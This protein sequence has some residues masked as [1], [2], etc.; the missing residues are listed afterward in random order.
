[1]IL[2][3]MNN[4]YNVLMEEYAL[5]LHI[6]GNPAFSWWIRHVLVKRNHIIGNL[7]SKYWVRRHKFDVKISKSVQEAKSFDEDNGNN[8][9]L[10]GICKEMKK[11]RPDFE[12]WEKEI[13][14]LPPG[15]QKITCHMIFDVKMGKS[16][17][18]E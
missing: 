16:T 8:L 1:M 13:S 4:S 6:A 18:D 7:K 17:L 10:V 14:E 2:K 9:W 12:V 3:D 11:I 5:Q 15:Y